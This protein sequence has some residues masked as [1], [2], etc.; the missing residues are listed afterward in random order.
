MTTYPTSSYIRI[1][2]PLND[3]LYKSPS[4]RLSTLKESLQVEK[5]LEGFAVPVTFDNVIELILDHT[6]HEDVPINTWDKNGTDLGTLLNVDDLLLQLAD[7]QDVYQYII[8]YTPP[9]I[10][11]RRKSGSYDIPEGWIKAERVANI[12]ESTIR[13]VNEYCRKNNLTCERYAEGDYYV[14]PDLKL[15]YWIKVIPDYGALYQRLLIIEEA[16]EILPQPD[17]QMLFEIA[18]NLEEQGE[19][20]PKGAKGKVGFEKF[21][22]LSLGKAMPKSID[23]WLNQIDDLILLTKIKRD[24]LYQ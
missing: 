7:E 13:T 4:I 3:V 12:K 18:E 15:D 5:D 14:Y 16:I 23:G 2:E 19:Y 17:L 11:N 22:R 20:D 21:V 9:W 8:R 24:E 10:R 6:G 1:I